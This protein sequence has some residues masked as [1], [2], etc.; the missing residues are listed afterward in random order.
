MSKREIPQVVSDLQALR[1]RLTDP[2]AWSKGLFGTEVT[3]NCLVG[4]MDVIID[5]DYRLLPSEKFYIEAKNR[6]THCRAAISVN[7]PDNYDGSIVGYNDASR[8]THK[9]ILA[10]I[11]TA[12]HNEKTKVGIKMME[13]IVR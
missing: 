9:D 3:S 2:E 12:L 6:R 4:A 10:L 1:D 11:D 5:R 8:T 13:E 7:I